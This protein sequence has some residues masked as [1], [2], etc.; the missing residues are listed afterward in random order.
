M[1]TTV[2]LVDSSMDIVCLF[3]FADFRKEVKPSSSKQRRSIG[4]KKVSEL[5]A[6]H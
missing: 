3:V 5:S 6:P 1:N 2:S 4:R